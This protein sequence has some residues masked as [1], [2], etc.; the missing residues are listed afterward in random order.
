VRSA[1]PARRS[2][3]AAPFSSLVGEGS[4]DSEDNRHF[5]FGLDTNDDAPSE[6][7]EAFLSK[8]DASRLAPKLRL[9][10][11][12]DLKLN[13]ISR[14]LH[15]RRS[16]SSTHNIMVR[17]MVGLL[18]RLGW[19]VY[20]G[21]VGIQGVYAMADLLAI[22]GDQVLFVE[23][24][25]RK[26]IEKFAKHV[27]KRELAARVPFCF[28]GPVPDDFM[29]SLPRSAYAIA[30]PNAPMMLNGERV[31]HFYRTNHDFIPRFIGTTRAGRTKSRITIQLNGLRLEEDVSG[32]LW[33]ALADAM[34]HRGMFQVALRDGWTI[35][36]PRAPIGMV[37]FAK[38]GVS[39][40][41]FSLK[42]RK[43]EVIL[44]LGKI[45]VEAELRGT[46]EALDLLASWLRLVEFP[47]DLT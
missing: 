8:R 1:A 36:T 13:G 30:H 47:L 41:A 39:G 2:K 19:R 3:V 11:L 22:D 35:K 20:P 37:P 44:K 32:F 31:P 21:G 10:F 43:S 25:T 7:P 5:R 46:R 26:N 33:T 12:D 42:G 18:R 17:D 4:S 6:P 45:P 14:A 24:L 9:V 15:E 28:V 27:T 40:S 34:H 29:A 23:C 38:H 16:E